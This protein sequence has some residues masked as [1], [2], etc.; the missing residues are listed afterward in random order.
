MKFRVQ[1]FEIKKGQGRWLDREISFDHQAD[2]CDY[3]NAYNSSIEECFEDGETP[4]IYMMAD[5]PYI[6][7]D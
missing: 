5:G 2:A 6:D 4:D 7:W 1:I 3:I